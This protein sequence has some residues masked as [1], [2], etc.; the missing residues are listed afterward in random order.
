MQ[1]T[2]EQEKK[3]VEEMAF[4]ACGKVSWNKTLVRIHRRIAKLMLSVILS[5]YDLVE[6]K[7]GGV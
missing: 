5:K 7:E 1:I 3:L 2:S 4:K 6:K